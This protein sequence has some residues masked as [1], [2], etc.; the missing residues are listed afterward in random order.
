V[1]HETIFA[2]VDLSKCLGLDKRSHNGPSNVDFRTLQRTGPLPL[3][4]LRGVGLPDSLI[5]YLPR[6]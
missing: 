1:L 2:D 3:S 6:C 5:D 4:F